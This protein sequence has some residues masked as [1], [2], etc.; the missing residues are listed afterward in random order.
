MTWVSFL[1]DSR[2]HALSLLSSA[3]RYSRCASDSA[4]PGKKSRR[5]MWDTAETYVSSSRTT[6]GRFIRFGAGGGGMSA[7][8]A[9]RLVSAVEFGHAMMGDGRQIEKGV[10]WELTVCS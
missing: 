6:D 4:N 3:F 2:I 10:R 8:A 9:L 7:P 1:P 5:M